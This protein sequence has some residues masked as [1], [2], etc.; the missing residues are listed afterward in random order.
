MNSCGVNIPSILEQFVNIDDI[1][2][3]EEEYYFSEWYHT[4]KDKVNTPKSWIFNAKCL[5]NGEIDALIDDLDGECFARTDS[6]STKPTEPYTSSEDIKYSFTN[7]DRCRDYKKQK[8]I[9]REYVYGLSKEFRCYIHDRKLRGISSQ[10]YITEKQIEEVEHIVN[11][12]THYTGYDFYSCDFAFHNDK[13]MLI[14]IN[15]PVW[16]FATSG[17]FDLDVP[18][19]RMIL[20]GDYSPDFISYPVVRFGDLD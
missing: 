17:E 13:L 10:I 5:N 8:I 20:F 12:I 9:I 1:D 11:L 6:C 18:A 7:S 4:I 2:D 14:E 19:D 15:S 16:L 3:Y